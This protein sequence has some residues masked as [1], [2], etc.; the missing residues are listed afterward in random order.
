MTKIADSINKFFD[1]N[2]MLLLETLII[3]VV[4]VVVIKVVL[5]I[6]KSILKRQNKIDAIIFPFI[7]SIVKV[8]L[9]LVLII[10]IAGK[11][12]FSTTS[13]ATILG[14][15]GLAIS[16]ALQSSLSNIVNGVFLMLTKPFV[17]GSVVSINGV[18]GV[19]E[20]IGLIYT[21][22]KTV[23]KQVYIP[24]SDVATAQISDLS[25]VSQRRY[26]LKLILSYKEDIE[27]IRKIILDVV[28]LDNGIS[29][30]DP[31]AT[32]VVTNLGPSGM[33]ITLR[34]WVVP[35]N[36]LAFLDYI[37][38]ALKKR[39]DVENVVIPGSFTEV[40]VRNK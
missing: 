35:T 7:R 1:E 8:L 12:G 11:L 15:V 29:L 2:G 26:D 37:H 30:K 25:V 13:L 34:V 19:V 36:Y 5:A 40:I 6:L 9:W 24:N 33:E 31:Q 18:D 3:L 28:S 17:R 38:E 23:D 10:T 21:K 27:R 32:V 16:L 14:A 20:S 4:G 39:F 22:L